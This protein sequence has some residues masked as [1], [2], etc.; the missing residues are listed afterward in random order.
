MALL[1][2]LV[3][4]GLI[5]LLVFGVFWYAT[6]NIPFFVEFAL[7]GGWFA[8]IGPIIAGC[9]IV[10]SLVAPRAARPPSAETPHSLGPEQEPLL[11]AFVGRIA[12]LIGA[13]MP[14]R[15]D[16]DCRVNASAG[17]VLPFRRAMAGDFVL[18]LGLPMVAGLTTQQF[19]G[20]VAH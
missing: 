5:G 10:A 13:P 16:V 15:V 2:T 1:S 12:K 14:S 6:H 8:Y 17:L 18:T 9:L 3:Y 11:F 7:F 4:V 20:V 19:A